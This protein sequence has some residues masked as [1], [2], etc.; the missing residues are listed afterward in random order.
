M[1]LL[2]IY[3]ESSITAVTGSVD[4]DAGWLEKEV[5]GI[6]APNVFEATALALT[7]A[8]LIKVKTVNIFTNDQYLLKF[9]MPPISVK[10]TKTVSVRGWGD[11]GMGGNPHQWTILYK[12]FACG[13]WRIQQ[14]AKLPGTE[15]IYHECCESDYYKTT[16]RSVATGCY[17]RIYKG[18]W[19]SA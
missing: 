7:D 13:S 6:V 17:R 18:V 3:T 15:A 16:V 4:Q 5:L 1:I 19:T 8:A 10:P 9:L 11:V 2:G 14:S 12:L